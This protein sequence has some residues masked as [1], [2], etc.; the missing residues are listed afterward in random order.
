MTTALPDAPEQL[1]DLTDEF[2]TTLPPGTLL[3]RAHNLG[4]DHPRGTH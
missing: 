3:L 1:P 4:G 2:V